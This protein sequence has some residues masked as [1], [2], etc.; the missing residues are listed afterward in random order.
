[1]GMSIAL[2]A[3]SMTFEYDRMGGSHES[4]AAG[5]SFPCALGIDIWNGCVR[6]F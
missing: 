4:L 5:V 6:A 3:I 2:V 1:M